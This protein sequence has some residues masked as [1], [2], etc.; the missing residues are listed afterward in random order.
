MVPQVNDTFRLQRC[1][2]WCAISLRPSYAMSGTDRTYGGSHATTYSLHP[3]DHVSAGIQLPTRLRYAMSGT[4]LAYAAARR[5]LRNQGVFALPPYCLLS[6]YAIGLCAC[7]AV[8]GTNTAYA[9]TR[10]GALRAARRVAVGAHLRGTSLPHP[11][12]RSLRDAR[13]CPTHARRDV[14][15]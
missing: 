10:R 13:Y 9:A 8:S 7:Y 6:W 12:T 4:D 14:R 5:H 1:A 15:Y 2:D 3:F 11:P